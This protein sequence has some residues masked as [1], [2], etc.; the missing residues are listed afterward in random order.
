MAH[1]LQAP[2][3]DDLVLEGIRVV[4]VAPKTEANVGAA[5][6]VCGNFEVMVNQSNKLKDSD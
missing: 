1:N 6:R 4:L 5:A 2:L 3:P